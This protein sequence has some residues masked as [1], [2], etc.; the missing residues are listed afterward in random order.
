MRVVF[1]Y[2][3]VLVEHVDEREY[4]HILGISPDRDPY[5]GWLAYAL[6]RAGFLDEQRQYLDLL[7]TLTG[8]SIEACAEYVEHT[9]LDPHVRP[10]APQVLNELSADHS[11]VLFSNMAKPW[12]ETALRD[13]DL[14]AA[15]DSLVVSSEIERPKP[16]PRGYRR[17]TEDTNDPV[18]MLSDEFDEDL[19]VAECFGMTTVWLEQP[20]D[21]LY[22]SPEYAIGGLEALPGVLE[23]IEETT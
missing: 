4:A 10:E 20:D 11:L 2:G 3:G 21:P 9:W 16:H 1:D 7:A 13:H 12:V 15:F 5:P 19:L 14:L 22:G 17:C 18:V 8:A 23:Q 6:F